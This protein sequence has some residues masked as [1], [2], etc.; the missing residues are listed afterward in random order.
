MPRNSWPKGVSGNP[1]GMPRRVDLTNQR[2]GRWLVLHLARPTHWWCRCDCGTE[3]QVAQLHLRSGRSQSCGCYQKER[4]SATNAVHQ[5]AKS[6]EYR[7][8]SAMRTRCTNPKAESWPNYGGRGIRI[9]D[10]WMASFASFLEDMGRKP[11]RVH[12]L[13]RINPNGDYCPENCRWATPKEQ[14]QTTRRALYGKTGQT[15][16]PRDTATTTSG[17]IALVENGSAY[18]A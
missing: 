8:W 6:A 16:G 7:T 1:A 3:R 15:S 13:D 17:Q 10:R 18:T 5:M 14:A 2:V 11:S 4:A 9:C 12:S